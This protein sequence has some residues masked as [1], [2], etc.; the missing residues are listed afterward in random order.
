[1]GVWTRA[2]LCAV[3][4]VVG[5]LLPPAASADTLGYCDPANTQYDPLDVP[6]SGSPSVA[7]PGVSERYEDLAGVRTRILEAGNPNS[8]TAVV[9]LHG[10]PGSAADWAPLMSMVAATG[11]RAVAFDMPG[12]GHAAPVWDRPKTLAAA[13]DYLEAALDQLG[14]R[15]VHLVVHD[16]GGPIG[17]EWATRHPDRLKSAT[18]IDTGLL[19]GYKDSQLAS[20]SRTPE[21]GELFWLQMTRPFFLAGIQDGQSPS[22]P[23]PLD[24]ANRLY[25]DLDRETR[26]TI[27]AEYRA[28]DEAE[29]NAFAERQASIL[30]ADSGRPALVLWGARD[31]YLPVA[32]ADRQRQ[33][34]P[35]A[36][37]HVF[38]DS[39]HWP[40][41]DNAPRAAA[42]IVPF[43]QQAVARTGGPEAV[44]GAARRH[45]QRCKHRPR[46]RGPHL[47]RCAPKRHRPAHD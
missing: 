19:L 39:G 4:V 29:V 14:I 23:L 1:M 11:T 47:R 26:C 2:T 33:G 37:I 44:R 32:M 6:K 35:S 18:L 43:L 17:M 22:R 27:I 40:F 13:T 7:A 25:D 5:F 30:A 24:F 21:L 36:E 28:A 41:V 8:D 45:R 31:P 34:F 10:S 42:L 38:D 16:L 46:S 12:F 9:F 15:N 3:A 20:I